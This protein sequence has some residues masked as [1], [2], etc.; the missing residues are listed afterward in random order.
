[1]DLGTDGDSDLKGV[2][3][4]GDQ[5]NGNQG[6]ITVHTPPQLQRRQPRS[7]EQANGNQGNITVRTP[8]SCSK[9]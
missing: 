8:R 3:D 9:G 5:A 6:N 2:Y 7:F 1:M 4:G